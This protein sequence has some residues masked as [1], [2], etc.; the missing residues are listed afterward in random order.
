MDFYTVNNKKIIEE[1]K[2]YVKK[3]LKDDSTGHDWFH[4]ERVWKMAKYIA[5]EE[6]NVDLFVVELAALLHDIADWKFQGGDDTVSSRVAEEWLEKLGVDQ[7][8]IDH[9]SEIAHH[10]SFK[11]AKVKNEIKTKEGMIVQD[12]DRLDAMGAIGIARV[13][14]M[15]G[16]FNVIIYDPNVK[17]TLHPSFDDYK[18]HQT[19]SINHFYEKLLLLKDMMNTKTGRKLAQRRHKF[20]EQFLKEFFLEWDGKI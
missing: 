20:L 1:T 7:I 11:G 12:A 17:P 9:V 18:K 5:E 2:I 13:F 15:G 3:T 4:I 16:K 14:A 8:T 10:I 6:G 19:S